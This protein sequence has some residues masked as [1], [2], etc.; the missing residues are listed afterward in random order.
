MQPLFDLTNVPPQLIQVVAT[1]DG[2][3]IG[4]SDS[5][6]GISLFNFKH[7]MTGSAFDGRTGS[8]ESLALSPDHKYAANAASDAKIEIFSLNPIRRR[9]VILPKHPTDSFASTAPRSMA[10]SSNGTMLEVGL[11][12]GEMYS[13][14]TADA[15]QSKLMGHSQSV[16][17]LG[18][19][20]D[21]TTLVSIGGDGTIRLW[22]PPLKN[23]VH[24]VW[25]VSDAPS[26]IGGTSSVLSPDTRYMAQESG[27]AG[28]SDPEHGDV[29]ITIRDTSTGSVMRRIRV[30][31]VDVRSM[32]FS[33]GNRWLAAVSS[34][35]IMSDHNHIVVWDTAT[36]RMLV[37]FEPKASLIGSI[38]FS[39]DGNLL[40]GT[41]Q[42]GRFLV[43]DASTGEELVRVTL[44]G[45]ADWVAQFPNHRYDGTPDGIDRLRWVSGLT[46]APV[47]SRAPEL[48]AAGAFAALLAPHLTPETLVTLTGSEKLPTGGPRLVIETH[49]EKPGAPTIAYNP[50]GTRLLLVDEAQATIWNPANGAQVCSLKGIGTHGEAMWLDDRRIA[51]GDHTR[52]AAVW[53][54]ATGA[55]AQTI[56]T[57]PAGGTRQSGDEALGPVNV[58]VTLEMSPDHK[59]IAIGNLE[60]LSVY[61][62]KSLVLACRIPLSKPADTY[63]HFVFNAANQLLVT[64][65]D[66]PTKCYDPR[67]GK[68]VHSANP[69]MAITTGEQ[70]LRSPDGTRIATYT[71]DPE[72][73]LCDG[74]TGKPLYTLNQLSIA[75]L[76]LAFS[77]DS[78]YSRGRGCCRSGGVVVGEN[79]QAHRYNDRPH[80]SSER[81]RV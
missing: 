65:A 79:R 2:K 21:G 72:V 37:K 34:A 23:A 71:V 43:C 7:S 57:A 66:K 55:E 30:G 63:S 20:G 14:N 17:A 38:C 12:D 58:D 27:G 77:P 10:F 4:F 32:A 16:D 46:S 45:Q 67:T 1:P 74:M 73:T 40:I 68:V 41:E 47:G 60:A 70:Y 36:G 69:P 18:F 8:S 24:T 53:D 15:V 48:H 54:A 26:S 75:T 25:N 31:S 59:W 64:F 3:T 13:I 80:A 42:D 11:A 39:P 50:S 35:G 56:A 6:G 61:D 33:H 9:I 62:T 19:A 29:S 22:N 81:P 49:E 51:S 52:H 44:V 78:R 5:S 28:L 76:T